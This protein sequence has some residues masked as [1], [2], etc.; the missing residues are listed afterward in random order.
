MNIAENKL[1]LHESKRKD[2]KMK[3][4]ISLTEWQKNH[5]WGMYH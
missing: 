5:D 4:V 1:Y 2:D 3:E